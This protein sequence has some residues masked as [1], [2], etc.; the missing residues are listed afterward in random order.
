MRTY[1]F[2]PYTAAPKTTDKNAIRRTYGGYAHCPARNKTT[3]Y[4]LPNCTAFVH[5]MWLKVITDAKG[6]TKAREI[7]E[8]MC[9]NDAE[10]YWTFKD[11][12][13]RGQTPKL[14]ATMV[15]EGKDSLAGHVM[16]VTTIK[17]NGD[18]IA[19]GS[20]YSGA[21]FYTKTYY[22]SKNYNF[23]VAKY[24][25]KGFIY[26]PYEF[27]YKCGTPVGR[28]ASV[29]QIQVV[30][31]ALNVRADASTHEWS[32]GIC[33]TGIYN[34]LDTSYDEDYAWYKIGEDQWIANN[35]AE[36]WC[37]LLPVQQPRYNLTMEGLTKQEKDSMVA[38]CEAQDVDYTVVEV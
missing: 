16:T 3:G 4:T 33:N 22:K 38:W 9:W 5:A 14:G 34:I 17:D 29:R 30:A 11:G 25:F 28:D 37:T 13:E 6:L 1:L 19:T 21:K 7:E 23:N 18:V 35:K 20:D 8:Q 32:C 2:K 36:T 26:I 15:W 24:T 31:S 27:V 12:F 10:Q